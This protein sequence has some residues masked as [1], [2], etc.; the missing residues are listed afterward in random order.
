MPGIPLAAAKF[1]WVLSVTLSGE[2]ESMRQYEFLSKADCL[3]AIEPIETLYLALGEKSVET[4]C[5]PKETSGEFLPLNQRMI[6]NL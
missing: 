4:S 2:P 5:E 3:E 6:M 1:V